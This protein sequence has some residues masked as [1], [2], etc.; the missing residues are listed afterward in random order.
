[1]LAFSICLQSSSVTNLHAPSCGGCTVTILCFKSDVTTERQSCTH[2]TAHDAQ[3]VQ[4]TAAA[5]FHLY[6]VRDGSLP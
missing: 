2:P 6:T 4:T 5:Q 3:W 1:M